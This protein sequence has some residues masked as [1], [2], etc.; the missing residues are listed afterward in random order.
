MPPHA[1][2]WW[3]WVS[4]PMSWP[5]GA[6]SP[7]GRPTEPRSGQPGLAGLNLSRKV[8]R[9]SFYTPFDPSSQKTYTGTGSTNSGDTMVDPQVVALTYRIEHGRSVAYDDPPPL[10]REESQFRL[11]VKG[12]RARFKLKEHFAT[13]RDARDAVA[14]YIDSWQMS[15]DLQGGPDSLRLFFQDSEIV[16]RQPRPG[17]VRLRTSIRS[18]IPRVSARLQV[19]RSKY[20]EPP[21]DR[22][23]QH[24][25][26]KTMHMRYIGYRRGK[27][28]LASMAYFCLTVLE[29]TVV[30][31]NRRRKVAG[32]W[33]IEETVLGRISKLS[34]T[35]GGSTARKAD[36]VERPLTCE[37]SRFLDEAT[38]SIILHV[39]K[40]ACSPNTTS[41]LTLDAIA[42]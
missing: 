10:I 32:E 26:V 24:P 5:L 39:A 7:F 42:T 22:N 33:R 27:E 2:S 25:D 34:S 31:S 1:P 40:M 6:D 3:R 36:G 28:P 37:E 23:F 30:G 41:E 8:R 4:T 35:R 29:H 11:Q 12:E 17:V 18:G 15:A 19:V 21:K 16:D 38:K 14:E 13:E 9:L 20:P